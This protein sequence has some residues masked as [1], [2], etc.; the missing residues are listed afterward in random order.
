MGTDSSWRTRTI[1]EAQEPGY[2]HPRA[3]CS[4]CGR[5][6]DIPWL[7]LLRRPGVSRDTFIGNLPVR[8]QRCGN[9]APIIDVQ[10]H[11]NTQ[12]YGGPVTPTA[13]FRPSSPRSRRTLVLRRDRDKLQAPPSPTRGPPTPSGT[14]SAATAVPGLF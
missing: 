8:C 2:S 9:A 10:H 6:T 3:V 1:A 5:V 7:L 13:V 4:G 12:G 11:G 14:A